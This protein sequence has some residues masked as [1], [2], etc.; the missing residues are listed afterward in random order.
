[1]ASSY[2]DLLTLEEMAQGEQDNTWGS[3]TNDNLNK[4]EQAIKG[5][6]AITMAAADITLTQ[7][8]GGTGSGSTNPANMIL[9]CSGTISAN[10]NI[11]IP[12]F[13][14]IYVVNNGTSQTAAETVS[15][16]TSGGAALEIPNGEVYFVWCDGTDCFT[17]NATLSGTV[18]LATNALQLGAVVAASYAQLA[19]KNSWTKPQIVTANSRTLT[20]NAYTPDADTDGTILIAQSEITAAF[21][22]NNPTGTPVDG[23]ILTFHLEQHDVTPRGVTWGSNY[24]WLDDTAIELTQTV[25]KVDIF[26]AQYNGNLAKWM[27]AG[28]TQNL[29]RS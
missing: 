15:I 12:A 5:R 24:L 28:V 23:Q 2:S 17:I 8:N 11:I 21:T 29:P 16:K 26:T 14:A 7:V 27:M 20:A 18:A 10:I 6:L 4:L 1:M 19:V 9:D 13:S 22:I 25:D 3:K